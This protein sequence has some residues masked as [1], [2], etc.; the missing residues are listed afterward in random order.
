MRQ[1]QLQH[2]SEISTQTSAFCYPLLYKH[3]C[4]AVF[5]NIGVPP[6]RNFARIPS[7]QQVLQGNVSQTQ[8]ISVRQK[9]APGV[10]VDFSAPAWNFNIKF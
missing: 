7:T 1:P 9:E 2:L 10:F 3:P 4:R 6:T 5:G 8:N